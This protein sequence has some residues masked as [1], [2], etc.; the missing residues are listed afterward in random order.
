MS[1]MLEES[2][3][4]PERVADQLARDADLYAGLGERLRREPPPAGLTIARGSSDHA[5]AYGA[6]L[7]TLLAGLPV[8]SLPPSLVT[9]E[10]AR[11]AVEGH[12]AVAVSQ[13]GRSPD[14][15]AC[16]EAA[17]QAGAIAVAV[18]ND[19]ASPLAD[20]AAT[21]LPQRAGPERSVAA[22]K[23]FITSLTALARLAV[24]WRRD[25]A[26]SAALERLPVRLRHAADLGLAADPGWLDGAGHVYVVAR[27]AG[28]PVAQEVALKLKE[29]CALHAE[30]FSSAELRHGP[31]EIVDARFAVL[32]LALPGPGQADVLAAAR[33]LVAQ[34]ATVRIVGPAETGRPF[35]A[36]SADL[37]PRLAPIEAVQALYPLFARTAT[38]LGRDPDRPRTLAKVTETL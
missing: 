5:A 8:A 35:L 14:I 26:L 12:L 1:R 34:G 31:R 10:R 23:S 27:G 21:V 20:A 19:P 7:L 24:A 3:E 28:L 32:A 36:L 37:D 4:A 17:H 16:L 11:L 25:P 38:R 30:A 9:L 22:T 2:L 6:Y 29:T 15:V 13:S 18:V 33:E